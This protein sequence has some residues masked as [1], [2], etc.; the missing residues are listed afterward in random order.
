M[1]KEIKRKDVA[2][3]RCGEGKSLFQIKGKGRDI[4][5]VQRELKP[6]EERGAGFEI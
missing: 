4:W 1:R 5:R 3:S 6:S 2:A